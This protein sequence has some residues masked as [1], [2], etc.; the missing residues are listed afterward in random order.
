MSTIRAVDNP[1]AGTQC[2]SPARDTR[3]NDA[4]EDARASEAAALAG[5]LAAGHRRLERL[6]GL[7]HPVERP[8][9]VIAP[10]FQPADVLV[11]DDPGIQ[12]GQ[13][14]R[15]ATLDREGLA[16]RGQGGL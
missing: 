2:I 11:E 12:I 14:V 7:R 15:I 5:A 8:E 1:A 10:L 6:S 13:E 9:P 3:P 16:P 4:F